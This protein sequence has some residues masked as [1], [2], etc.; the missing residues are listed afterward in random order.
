LNLET[1]ST[2]P[3]LMLSYYVYAYVRSNG[4][5][6]YIGK[7]TGR[8]AYN[9]HKTIRVPADKQRIV[10]I[11]AGL[12]EVGSL[13]LERRLIR[14][15]GRKDIGTGVLRNLTDG[16]EGNSGA[17]RSNAFKEL[18]SARMKGNTI[19]TGR[20]RRAGW[21]S[22]LNVHKIYMSCL[23]CRKK[24]NVGNYSKHIKKEC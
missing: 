7:G 11:E 18:L 20:K 14:W 23:S 16:G 9:A 1:E 4:I 12:T 22:N 21:G 8:R 10:I 24:F 15:W 2:S 17:V 5:P 19:N 13:A 6:Y 3:I